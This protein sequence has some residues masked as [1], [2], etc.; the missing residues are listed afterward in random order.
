[1]RFCTVLLHYSYIIAR[2]IPNYFQESR[3]IFPIRNL[4]GAVLPFRRRHLS[5]DSGN[6]I[7]IPLNRP[8]IKRVKGDGSQKKGNQKRFVF[9]TIREKIYAE[10][11]TVLGGHSNGAARSGGR[12]RERE[13][14]I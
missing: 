7:A 1:M 2:S 13:R 14:G 10:S 4:A 11:E 6:T 5:D 3:E 12:K 8:K 9:E